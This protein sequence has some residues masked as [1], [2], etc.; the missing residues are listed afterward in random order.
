[1]S[2][3]TILKTAERRGLNAV[4]LTDHNTITGG[5]ETFRTGKEEKYSVMV[6]IGAEIATNMGDVTGLFLNQEIR[7]RDALEVIDSIRVQDGLVLIPHPFKGHK[8]DDIQDVI[9]YVDL[10]EIYNSRHPTSL[11]QKKILK[12]L[13]KPLV[14]G[15]DAH[16][17]REIG[18]CQTILDEELASEEEIRRTLLR[19]KTTVRG[20]SSP[21]YFK[22]MSQIIKGLKCKDARV[23]MRP[24]LHR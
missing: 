13:N 19:G 16:F 5:A 7:S 17:P 21:F 4:A 1:M 15:S 9:N 23:F 22:P 6:I 20:I 2:P 18:L 12:T 10:L 14:G 8:F 11:E 3:K 24:L